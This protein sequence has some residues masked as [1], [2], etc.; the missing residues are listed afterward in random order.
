MPISAQLKY[1][2]DL[3]CQ[4]LTRIPVPIRDFTTAP[5][6]MIIRSFDVNKPGEEIQDLKGGVAGGTILEG[7]LRVGDE[8]EIRPGIVVREKDGNF[9]CTSIFSRIVQLKAENNDLLYAV[10]GGL[11]GVGMQVDPSLT[12]SDHLTG[13]LLGHP[14]KLPEVMIEIDISFYLLRRLLGVKS[15]GSGKSGS[16][17]QKLQKGEVLMVNVGSK[18]AG[19]N[20]IALSG[21]GDFAKIKF[22]FPVCASIGDKVALSRR[23][24]KNFRLIGWGEI[25]K[26]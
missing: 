26:N 22:M 24:Q 12:R 20:V 15:E 23:I 16:R 6:M 8:V 5:K 25:K 4:Y 21:K 13:H 19:A 18:S 17:V 2:L 11:I 1:N 7:V 9:R 10:P 14:G 3:V